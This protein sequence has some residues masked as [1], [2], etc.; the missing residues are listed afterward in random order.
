MSRRT[1]VASK[2]IR[3]A[4]E[5]EQKLVLEGKGT[6][7]WTPEQQQSII[8]YGKAYDEDGK[9]F[10]GHHMK[11]AE[12]H[13]EFQGDADNIQFLTRAEHQDA[14]GGSF[15]NPTNGYY[16]FST[17]VTKDFGDNIYSPCEIIELSNPVI[18]TE[19]VPECDEVEKA[20]ES[21]KKE[22]CGNDRIRDSEINDNTANNVNANP[23]ESTLKTS[24]NTGRSFVDKVLGAVEV[25]KS[26]GER[27][28]VLSGIVKFGGAAFLAIVADKATSGRGGNRSNT[29]YNTDSDNGN[30]YDDDDSSSYADSDDCEESE[31][32]RDYPSERS[33]P[34][35]HDVSGYDR[36]QNG[37]TVHVNPYKRGGRSKE[38]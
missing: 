32:E 20:D 16:D 13:P 27:H 8:E 33:S 5:K 18:H 37:K 9:A 28:P 26:F 12:A 22:E 36:Q 3:E 24:A 23:T 11:S 4:W 6:R 35:E 30:Y 14:H 31:T 29:S 1:S 10:E 2:A 15:R 17:G 7:D 21:T 19:R 34:K 25:V 38:D